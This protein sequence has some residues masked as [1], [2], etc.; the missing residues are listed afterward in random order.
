MNRDVIRAYASVHLSRRYINRR[1]GQD[2]P[3]LRRTR[4]LRQPFSPARS[5]G[6][7][8]CDAERDVRAQL[9]A[10]FLQLLRRDPEAP[11]PVQAAQLAAASL[12]PPAGLAATGILLSK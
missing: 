2:D 10:Q 11:E 6:S 9:G 1:L 5:Q 3:A 7:A 12:L 8:S 4:Y